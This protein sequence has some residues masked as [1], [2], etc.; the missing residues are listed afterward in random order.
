MLEE[1]CIKKL[2]RNYTNL[3][4]E[5]LDTESTNLSTILCTLKNGV[6]QASKLLSDLITS[7]EDTI[8]VEE[9][10]FPY[11]I[12]L[13]V[14]DS[15]VR[16]TTKYSYLMDIEFTDKGCIK[17]KN[18]DHKQ[19]LEKIQFMQDYLNYR[20]AIPSDLGHC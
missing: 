2:K 15:I 10:K 16:E 19:V 8:E 4:F 6:E 7:N 9:D 5:M 1:D 11:I 20:I 18:K 14:Y 17:L 13:L 12:S 3:E